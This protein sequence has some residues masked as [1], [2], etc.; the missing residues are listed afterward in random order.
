MRK[1]LTAM[2]LLAAPMPALMLAWAPAFAAQQLTESAPML[3]APILDFGDTPWQANSTHPDDYRVGM[4]RVA[5]MAGAEVPVILAR[6]GAPRD[7]EGGV[8]QSIDAAEWRGKR[9]R[10][11]GR[12]KSL[13]ASF[14]QM[15]VHVISG[16][17]DK[18]TVRSMV[19]SP[20]AGTRD[21]RAQEIVIDVAD[22]ARDIVYGFTLRGQGA[23][24]GDSFSLEAVGRDV[25]LSRPPLA[26]P[27]AAP[28]MVRSL[29]AD[30]VFQGTANLGGG[31]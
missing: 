25:R 16:P 28:G 5:G 2:L 4:T 11:T 18:E 14:V 29:S 15:V 17:P 22:D 3:S 13:D 21:W 7:H 23:A 31:N 24:F 1:I 9:L 6:A 12:L 30:S 27:F 10:L 20:I 19:T 8:A 26:L